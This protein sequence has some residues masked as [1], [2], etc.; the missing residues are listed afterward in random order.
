MNYQLQPPNMINTPPLLTGATYVALLFAIFGLWFGRRVWI[1]A[2]ALA[3]ILGYA[4]H[5][6][7]GVAGVWI[8][9]FVGLCVGYDRAKLGAPGSGRGVY[10]ALSA[11]GILVLGALLAAHALPGFHNFLILDRVVFSDGAAPFTLYLNFDKTLVGLCILGFCH[12]ALLG[13]AS[14]WP[15]SLR[16]AVPIMI[17]NVVVVAVGACALG[18]LTWQPKWTPVFWIW[19]P[20][21]LLFVCLSEEAFFRGFIQRE[22][23]SSLQR[24][25][26]GSGVA[27]A[28]SSLLF[29]LAHFA[30]GTSYIVLA[31]AAGVGY[32]IVYHRTHSIEMSMLAHFTLNATHFLLF[33]YPQALGHT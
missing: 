26:Y 8:L 33:T 4:A 3:V 23:A 22:L 17:I 9:A 11:L 29:G 31:T 25:R 14:E 2:L 32:G 27:I 30:G 15:P 28:V 19:A 24:M 21:N 5:V 20:V 7:V 12:R 13:R 6:L 10:V 1:T 18:Y 16:R